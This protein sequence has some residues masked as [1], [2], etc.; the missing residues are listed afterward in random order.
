MSAKKL[1]IEDWIIVANDERVIRVTDAGIILSSS[2]PS[3][4]RSDAAQLA[5]EALN[6]V[7]GTKGLPI[8][9]TAKRRVR[10]EAIP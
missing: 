6:G 5:A 7:F 1:P 4:F 10:E 2:D 3:L 9:L 8:T